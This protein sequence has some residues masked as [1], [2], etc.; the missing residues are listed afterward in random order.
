MKLKEAKKIVLEKYPNAKNISDDIGNV[1]RANG[2]AI[3][4]G[5]GID[6][7]INCAKNIKNKDSAA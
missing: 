4:Y 6:V 5:V 7:W 2:K 3:A 1:L